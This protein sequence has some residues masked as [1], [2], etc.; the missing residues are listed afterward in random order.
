[1]ILFPEDIKTSGVDALS[2]LERNF[3][4]G[5]TLNVLRILKVHIKLK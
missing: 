4:R 1:M 5:L 2:N 3:K